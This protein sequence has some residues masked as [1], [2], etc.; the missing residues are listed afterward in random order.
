MAERLAKKLLLV[1]WDAADWKII[2]PLLASGQMPALAGLIEQGAMGNLATLRPI[3]SPM[4]W[5]SIATGKRADKHGILGF[6]EP[7]ADGSGIQPVSST[8]RKTKA[9]WN[10]LS[11]NGLRG[12]VINW[13]ASHPAEPIRGACVSEMFVKVGDAKATVMP[14]PPLPP[15]PA[16]SVW[17]PELSDSLAELRVRPQDIGPYHLSPFVPSLGEIPANETGPITGM[18][19]MLARCATVHAV[20]TDLMEREPWDYCAAYYEAI[21]HFCHGFMQYHPPRMP[22]VEERLFERYKHV[23]AGIYR[24]HDMMLERL[25]Q[26]AGDDATVILVS[27]HGFLSNELRPID[28]PQ[29]PA[30]PE[31]WHR[32]HG[33]IA[34][35]G[36][37][38]IR[39]E[40]VHGAT[41]LD[42]APTILASFG[43]PVGRDMDGKVLA[44]CFD[45][46]PQVE[47]V[48][49][50]DTVPGDAGMHAPETQIDPYAQQEAL[51][52]LVELGYIAPP[53]PDH[54]RAIRIATTESRF[55]LAGVYQDADRPRDALAIVE[56]LHEQ[57]PSSPRFRILL[58]SLYY[59]L[60]RLADARR[61]IESIGDAGQR[62]PRLNMT[63][64]AIEFAEGNVNAAMDLLTRAERV[65][66]RLPTLHCQI[67]VVYAKQRR[68]ADAERAFR[69]AL[70]IDGDAAL[71]HYGLGNAA[72]HLGRAEE[73]VEHTLR[74]VGLMHFFPRAHLQLGIALVRIGWLARA[75]EAFRTASTLRPAW[76]APHRFLTALHLRLGQ[77][78]EAKHHADMVR[79]LLAGP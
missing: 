76:V 24:F 1:G 47:R 38:V 71:A 40:R 55:N 29:H 16:D 35:K 37:H 60:G 68:W 54:E 53:D 23:V 4:L 28:T 67:G 63:L 5:N 6:I 22:H 9:F 2:D 46:P 73:A 75:T 39:D 78:A 34:M 43:V 41:L 26:L 17:P 14:A 30:G 69:K 21:D 57:D 36:P 8:S 65:E 7:R 12:H 58:A 33:V 13:F 62:S 56:Q 10:I 44:Q 74:A 15:P 3:L 18:R 77:A 32:Y 19:K 45:R 51:R 25:L 79:R 59:A 61:L 20:A 50:W 31:A 66:P 49:T 27:D 70:D 11:Q 52:Q 64:G 48:D 72:L 42:I